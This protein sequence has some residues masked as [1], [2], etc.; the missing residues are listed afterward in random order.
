MHPLRAIA[1]AGLVTALSLGLGACSD[2]PEPH[3]TTTSASSSAMD[4]EAS[5]TAVFEEYWRLMAS[6]DPA[7]PPSS[8]LKELISPDRAEELTEFAA[9]VPSVRVDGKDELTA[10]DT[11]LH[12]TTRATVEVCYRVH[13]KLIATRDGE[14][15]TAGDDLRSDPEGNPLK[16]GTIQVNKVTMTRSAADADWRVQSDE[17]TGKTTCPMSRGQS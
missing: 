10:S 11:T 12:S 5:A 7:E 8:R 16:E 1:S 15:W 6:A 9:V 17:I 14:G 13:Q 3:E 4:D 2:D